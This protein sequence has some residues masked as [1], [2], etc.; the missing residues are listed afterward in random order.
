MFWHSP[1]SPQ[2]LFR[3]LKLRRGTT[4]HRSPGCQTCFWFLLPWALNIFPPRH[5]QDPQSSTV[6]QEIT[7]LPHF[8]PSAFPSLITEHFLYSTLDYSSFQHRMAFGQM[9]CRPN[10]DRTRKGTQTP[11]GKWDRIEQYGVFRPLECYGYEHSSWYSYYHDTLWSNTI[12]YEYDN[13]S[14]PN[15]CYGHL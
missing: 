3:I 11:R 9:T 15:T 6:L 13:H 14:V 7:R 1:G 5:V 2:P 8:P 10:A 4:W 12:V